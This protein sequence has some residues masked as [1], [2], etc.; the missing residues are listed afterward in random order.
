MRT[1]MYNPGQGPVVVYCERGNRPSGYINN[2]T[3]ICPT[4]QLSSQ[5]NYV[6]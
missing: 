5:E 6:P 4:E 3:F 2:I 1:R